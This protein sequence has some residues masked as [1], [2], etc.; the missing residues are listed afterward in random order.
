M[1]HRTSG[2]AVPMIFFSFIPFLIRCLQL[3]TVLIFDREFEWI[4]AAL[5]EYQGKS[6]CLQCNFWYHEKRLAFY[7][8]L[9]KMDF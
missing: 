8:L 9:F 6:T 3:F 7:S 4:Q 1:D 2:K 5:C